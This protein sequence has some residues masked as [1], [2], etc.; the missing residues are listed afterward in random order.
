MLKSLVYDAGTASTVEMT[1]SELIESASG[2]GKTIWVDL[3]KPTDTELKSLQESFK[4]HPLAIKATTAKLTFPTPRTEIYEGS[5]Y[6]RWYYIERAGKDIRFIPLNIFIGEDYLITAREE[7]IGIVDDIYD[8]A[9]AGAFLS[10][11][12]ARLLHRVLDSIVDEFFP[13]LDETIDRVDILEDEMFEKPSRKQLKELFEYKHTLLTIHKII[14]PQRET[15]NVL[16]RFREG[17]MS[18]DIYPYFM[19]IYDH[20]VQLDDIVDTSRD[21]INGAM[22]IYLS[23]ISNK[24][25]EVMRRL[26][27]VATVFLPLTLLTGFFGMNLRFVVDNTKAFAVSVAIAAIFMVFV[28][29]SS[30]DRRPKV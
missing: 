25:N 23:S 12:S 1:E 27:L 28:L 16:T 2:M 30:R 18:P 13:L 24:L 10:K 15:I 6:V 3:V 7:R 22:D 5:A 8:A 21:V 17:F 26:T 4:L 20:Y 14:V 19:D 9:K 11:G 29:I